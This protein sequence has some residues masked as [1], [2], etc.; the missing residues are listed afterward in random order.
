[1]IGGPGASAERIDPRIAGKSRCDRGRYAEGVLLASI[2]DNPWPIGL[3]ALGCG[4][5]LLFLALR[6]GVRSRL[7]AGL[8][9]LVVGIG[10][11]G[12]GYLVVTPTEHAERVTRSFVDAVIEGRTQ[13][14]TALLAPDMRMHYGSSTNPGVPGDALRDAL[15]R[16]GNN[17]TVTDNTVLKLAG[18]PDTDRAAIV[19]L[20][21]LTDVEEGYGPTHSVW[22][23]R[24][25]EV[26]DTWLITDVTWIALNK[27]P[28][29]AN[30]R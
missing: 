27:S 3:A 14:A 11:I 4:A 1:M 28:P 24:V 12:T 19:D 13:A 9:F 21:C 26:N 7:Q 30:W 23:F 25:A 10:L 17:Y 5:V 6:D 15:I 20:A 18:T 16:F 29:P 2:L 8:V 22:Q